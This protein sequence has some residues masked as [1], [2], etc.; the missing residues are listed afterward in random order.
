MLCTKLLWDDYETILKAVKL[1]KWSR[2]HFP[3]EEIPD[4]GQPEI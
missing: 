4:K 1:N 2:D 3:A